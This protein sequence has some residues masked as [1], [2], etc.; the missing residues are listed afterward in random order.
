MIPVQ[1]RKHS[2]NVDKPVDRHADSVLE[3]SVVETE[4]VAILT[5][6]GH[7]SPPY[8]ADNCS[9]TTYRGVLRDRATVLLPGRS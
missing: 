1:N 4:R 5:E 7:T 2:L 6:I 3:N 8:C 9:I